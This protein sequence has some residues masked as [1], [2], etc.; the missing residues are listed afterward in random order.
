MVV[1]VLRCA[2]EGMT[3]LEDQ[4][5]YYAQKG[6]EQ[7]ELSEESENQK[8]DIFYQSVLVSAICCA[9]ICWRSS[10]SAS[11]I[12]K[13]IHVAGQ[14]LDGPA[15]P[16]RLINNLFHSFNEG[17]QPFPPKRFQHRFRAVLRFSTSNCKELV[18]LWLQ[19]CTGRDERTSDAISQGRVNATI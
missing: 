11:R 12:Y 14:N 15:V 17:I 6:D 18:L 5:L 13:L 1:V 19:N 7:T 8:L 16:H 3:G 10:T 2:P 9:V 4:H